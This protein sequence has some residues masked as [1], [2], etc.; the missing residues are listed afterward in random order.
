MDYESIV[1]LGLKH[2]G[3]STQGKNLSQ[4]LGY[5][6]LDTDTVMEK[7]CGKSPRQIYAEGGIEGFLLAEEEACIA[8]SKFFNSEKMVIATGGGIC[9]NPPALM[10][11][12]PA[13][14]F[15]FLRASLATVVERIVRKVELLPDGSF[16]NLPS[17]VPAS[18]VCSL[19][20]VREFLTEKF[21]KRQEI[22][23]T[24]ADIIVDVGNGSIE[25]NLQLIMNAIDKHI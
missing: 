22:Y 24:A 7:V 12:R 21:K 10:A 16:K 13:G 5:K 23:E 3:K 18:E 11:L 19:D 15:V 8:V 2:T 9:D 17:F 4:K 1:L 6:F 25:E 20:E 14:L